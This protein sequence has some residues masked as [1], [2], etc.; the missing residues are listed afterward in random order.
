MPGNNF[1]KTNSIKTVANIFKEELILTKGP[2]R[3]L[4]LAMFTNIPFI[5][6]VPYLTQALTVIFL[7]IF[8][9]KYQSMGS[10]P[11]QAFVIATIV[12][13]LFWYPY[14][15]QLVT[16]VLLGLI[17]ASAAKYPEGK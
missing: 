5:G 3:L 6:F 11:T 12:F 8:L 15:S 14:I 1:P 9:K 13:Q 17:Y 4:L 2:G 7:S 10:K 16:L